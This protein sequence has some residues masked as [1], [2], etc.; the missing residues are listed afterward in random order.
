MQIIENYQYNSLQ[1][2]AQNHVWYGR[3][4]KSFYYDI[5]FEQL[6]ENTSANYHELLTPMP[7]I[8]T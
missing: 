6:N 7:T 4:G 1:D 3:Q 2:Y 8:N 5:V